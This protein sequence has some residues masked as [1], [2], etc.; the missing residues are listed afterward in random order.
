MLEINVII[1]YKLNQEEKRSKIHGNK[2]SIKRNVSN[3]KITK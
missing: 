2:K 1:K 3:T